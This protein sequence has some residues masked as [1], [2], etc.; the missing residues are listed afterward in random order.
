MNKRILVMKLWN[1]KMVAQV[2]S[3][4]SSMFR[5]WC[6]SLHFQAHHWKVIFSALYHN[7]EFWLSLG[8]STLATDDLV[9]VEFS[10][11]QNGWWQAEVCFSACLLGPLLWLSYAKKIQQKKN[12]NSSYYYYYKGSTSWQELRC[13]L[14]TWFNC[15]LVIAQVP[16]SFP[17]AEHCSLIIVCTQ[18][19]SVPQ[20]SLCSSN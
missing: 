3:P 11:G 19:P 8:I 17:L 13:F 10:A 1:M 6:N 4:Y 15:K 9:E 18:P 20:T 12:N 7:G 5:N 14:P 16:R 2:S